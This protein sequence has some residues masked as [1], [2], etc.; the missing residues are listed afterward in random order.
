MLNMIKSSKNELFPPS[1]LV[2]KR[3]RIKLRIYM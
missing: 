3:K 2:I 1:D